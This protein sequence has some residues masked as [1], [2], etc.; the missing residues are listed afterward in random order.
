MTTIP[1]GRDGRPLVT[2]AMAAYSLGM[3]PGSFRGWAAR[4][5]VTASAYQANP[6]GGQPTALWD[7]ADI[8]DCWVVAVE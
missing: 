2:T 8:A 3:K 4:H 5:A 6:N 7:L 1:T